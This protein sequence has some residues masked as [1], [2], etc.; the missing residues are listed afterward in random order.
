ML[1]SLV[2][3]KAF[4]EK[5]RTFSRISCVCYFGGSPEPQLP[6]AVRASKRILEENSEKIFRMC[7]E[8]NGC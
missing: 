3:L 6:F 2:A 5:V 8:W 7:F 4:A 1:A